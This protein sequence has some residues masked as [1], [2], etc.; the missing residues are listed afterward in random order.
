M[1]PRTNDT[2]P[3]SQ[4]ADDTFPVSQMAD[5]T[6]PVFQMADNTSPVSQMADNTSPVFTAFCPGTPLLLFP[7]QKGDVFYSHSFPCRQEFP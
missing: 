1:L 6:F 2:F 3:V 4:M 7:Q 5:N